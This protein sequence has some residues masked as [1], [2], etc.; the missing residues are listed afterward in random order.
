MLQKEAEGSLLQAGDGPRH[1]D[2]KT[3]GVKGGTLWGKE[4][5]P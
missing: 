2:G 1:L 4:M 3:S 5:L